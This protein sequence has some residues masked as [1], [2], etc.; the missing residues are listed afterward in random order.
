MGLNEK[1]QMRIIEAL[2]AIVL[3]FTVFL[4]GV[5]ITK[6]QPSENLNQLKDNTTKL[7][8]DLS[9]QESFR[10]NAMAKDAH[11]VKGD[12]NNVI[13][14]PL[15]VE[16]CDNLEDNCI[17]TERPDSNNFVI[18]SYILSGSNSNFKEIRTIKA[19][20]WVTK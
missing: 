6:Q 7:L 11:L 18:A 4:L 12:L 14:T 10:D 20:L 8:D 17:R 5:Q 19:Y 3:I 9:Q 15:S 1:G 13:Q 2:I 16:I